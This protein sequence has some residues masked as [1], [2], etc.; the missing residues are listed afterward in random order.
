ML[1]L[2]GFDS[3]MICVVYVF[4]LLKNLLRICQVGL[5]KIMNSS[6]RIV[7]IMLILDR[8]LMFFF[9]F[10]MIEVMVMLVMIMIRMI[11]VVI[12]VF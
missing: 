9:M 5:V 1:W 8:C 7:R 12:V 6:S 4:R 10:S 3:G 11:L 2:K